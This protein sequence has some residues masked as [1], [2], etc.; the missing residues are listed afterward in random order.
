MSDEGATRRR[1]QGAD[2][3]PCPTASAIS[4]SRMRQA[5][6][7]D[8]SEDRGCWASGCRLRAGPALRAPGRAGGTRHFP[9]VRP[10]HAA[11]AADLDWQ[12]FFADARCSA[13]RAGAAEQPRPARGVLNIERRARRPR[14]ATPTA[15]P[16]QRRSDRLAGAHGQRRQQQRC[17]PPACR[18]QPTSSTCSAAC[19]ASATRRRAGAGQRGS[20]QG[21]ADQPGR[22]GGQPRTWRW[23]PT[24][25]CSRDARTLATR[26]ASLKLVQLRFDNGASSELDLRQAES[27][28]E[29][30]G[31]RWRSTR[32]RALDATRWCCCSAS[33]CRMAAPARPIAAPGLP[34][35]PVGLP[36]DVLLRR[37]TCARPSS[38]DRRQREHRRRARGLL[39]A[40]HADRQRRH[41]QQRPGRTCSSGPHLAWS[42]APQLLQPIFDAGRNQGNLQLARF[43]ATRPW[44]ST[45]ARAAG[46]PRGGRCAGRPRHAGRAGARAAGARWRPSRRAPSCPSCATATV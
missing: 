23:R 26:E 12:D 43:S 33:R 13:D 4:L 22:G 2:R 27:L 20:A 7:L 1:G 8:T 34:E 45:S 25:N 24:T 19:A 16:R 18:S 38:A 31:S 41:G 35:L 32:Q 44:R 21:G 15:G 5:D 42:F 11:P 37:P 28:L 14:C 6:S 10:R 29:A 46:L 9:H 30:R 3:R 39:A 36:S 17:T 40:H